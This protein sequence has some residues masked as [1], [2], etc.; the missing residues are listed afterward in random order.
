MGKASERAGLSQQER[1]WRGSKETWE[2]FN[3]FAAKVWPRGAWATLC[4]EES[5]GAWLLIN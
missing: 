1:E 5:L 2:V 4:L 3:G